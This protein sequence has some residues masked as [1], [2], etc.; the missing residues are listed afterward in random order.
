[1]PAPKG[2]EQKS[3]GHIHKWVLQKSGVSKC[4]ASFHNRMCIKLKVTE[5][6]LKSIE[7]EWANYYQLCQ[8]SEAKKDY[9]DMC[10][11]SK[12]KDRDMMKKILERVSKRCQVNPEYTGA[13]DEHKYQ[14][15][16][17]EYMST[18]EYPD[19]RSPKSYY[20]TA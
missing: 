12:F 13:I 20:L 18:P 5:D 19:P 7:E 8:Q 4:I 14:Y 11:A 6:H 17:D 1:M 10:T 9:D 15:I 2:E 3:D 16:G